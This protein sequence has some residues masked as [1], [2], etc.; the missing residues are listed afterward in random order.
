[1]KWTNFALINLF[2]I[3]ALI[4]YFPNHSLAQK[5]KLIIPV[6]HTSKVNAIA[7][8]EDGRYI[9]SADRTKTIQWD[10]NTGQI[11]QTWPI[12]D[13]VLSHHGK[14]LAL[15][16][17]NTEGAVGLIET[18]TG[19]ERFFGDPKLL[20]K[21]PIA[22][23]ADERL[24]AVSNRQEKGIDIWDID[25]GA[26][27]DAVPHPGESPILDLQ[28]AGNGKYLLI[29]SPQ[30]TDL[31]IQFVIWD[32]SK[33]EKIHE[34]KGTR[35]TKLRASISPDGKYLVKHTFFDSDSQKQHLTVEDLT[36]DQG[37]LIELSSGQTIHS[38]E[39]P[40][41][42]S[43]YNDPT[44]FSSDGKKVATRVNGGGFELY[45]I[46]TATSKRYQ[47]KKDDWIT[48][49]S[50]LPNN[51]HLI[52]GFNKGDLQLWSL[53]AEKT[54][55]SFKGTLSVSSVDLSPD[56]STLLTG[57]R[58]ALSGTCRLVEWDLKNGSPNRSGSFFVPD[59]INTQFSSDG[60]RTMISSMSSIGIW[61]RESKML[62]LSLPLPRNPAAGNFT[63]S[64]SK[65]GKLWSI[66]QATGELT[67]Q[68]L[69]NKIVLDTLISSNEP[70]TMTFMGEEKD[71]PPHI[72]QGVILTLSQSNISSDGKLAAVAQVI[73]VPTSG[74]DTYRYQLK[75]VEIQSG[76]IN[77]RAIEPPLNTLYYK[78]L[79]SP[80]GKLVLV[81]Y[82]DSGLASLSGYELYT[83]NGLDK[84]QSVELKDRRISGLAISPDEKLLA[85]GLENGDILLWEVGTGQCLDTLA[86]HESSISDLRFSSDGKWLLSGGIDAKTKVWDIQKREELITLI[87]LD[88]DNWVVTTPNGLFDASIGAMERMYYEVEYQ[89]EKEYIELEQLKARYY[90]PGLLSKVLGFSEEAIRPVDGFDTVELFPK[91][92][93][94]IDPKTD[95]LKVQLLE[96]NGGI[97]KVSVFINNKE[98]LEEANPPSRGEDPR[99][100]KE[101]SIDLST[102]H[103]YC[104]QHPDSVNWLT[105]RAENAKGWLKSDALTLPY[106]SL[107]SHNQTAPDQNSKPQTN[108]TRRPKMYVLSIGT[109]NYSGEQLDL[110]YGDQDAMM[111]AK[112]M[113][114]IGAALFQNGDSIEVHC[115]TTDPSIPTDLQGSPIPWQFASKTNIQTTFTSI[116]EQAKAEDII[117]VYLSGHGVSKRGKEEV[118]FY[119]LTQGIS[120]EDDLNDPATLNAFTI[121]SREM[122]KWINDIPALKQ[123][124]VID[125]CNSGQVIE[126]L[127]GGSKQLNSSQIRALD[128]M[129]DRTGMFILAGS[130][131]DK[132]SYEA[133]EYGQGLL[134]YAILQGMLGVATRKDD[135]G[136]DIVDVMKL[137]Q[138]ARDQ[139]PLLAAKVNGIQTPMLGFPG[140][141]ASFDIGILD[142]AAKVNIP[143]GN[144]KPVIIRSMFMNKKTVKDDLQLTQKLEDKFRKIAS[145]GVRANLVYVDV[146]AYPGAYKITGLYD[147]SGENITIDLRL[148]HGEEAPITIEIEP[149]AD[150]DE[151]AKLILW[152]VE[153]ELY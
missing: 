125:A 78:L 47:P 21:V 70:L 48:A 123:V 124:L 110:K 97:G 121:S 10:R 59:I 50:F 73:S 11:R 133:S 115:F 86:A 5:P 92:T 136:Q 3:G 23:S 22:I 102:F 141:G 64:F 31:P 116:K 17:E 138:Y 36:S 1:M 58:G 2:L 46:N 44:I 43:F 99:R 74:P 83:T 90:E 75:L 95:R 6:G 84:I 41:V 34:F 69:T 118:Q 27:V 56:Q 104:F 150:P 96:R 45:D 135:Q 37:D 13:L 80:R 114:S 51:K 100:Q 65:D 81:C 89:G 149:T 142:D 52:L 57:N 82:A 103:K 77:Q 53:Q 119:Y 12:P 105:V 66:V 63:P 68:D 8:S 7:F 67:L 94:K 134:T 152:K 147:T 42:H 88:P 148:F 39:K 145:K 140:Q 153:L 20:G 113:Q 30:D 139:V 127:M 144:K 60:K 117:M 130:A 40:R 107:D 122:T 101:I 132:L 128:R 62:D 9:F 126:N 71:F 29:E 35:T 85:S 55:Q 109:S 14:Y 33:K 91:V 143:I 72:K 4:F 106:T 146:N 18:A 32:R 16:K 25:S 108:R 15:F 38:F 120:S 112:A 24:L 49:M 28:F 98:V 54:I 93:A 76:E 129:K 131:S 19:L 26:L 87:S 111:M 79:F 61:N 137:F 151:L